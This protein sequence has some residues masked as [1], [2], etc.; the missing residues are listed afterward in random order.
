MK[1]HQQTG[2]TGTT[3]YNIHNLVY[4]RVNTR[5]KN[6]FLE[7]IQ[8][9][10]RYFKSP[11]LPQHDIVLNI[12]DFE[13]DRRHC[14]VINHKIYLREDYLFCE[15]KIKNIRYR[16]EIK[17]LDQEKLILNVWE[18]PKTVKQKLFP[19]LVAQN[20]FLRP[21]IDYVLLKKGA[22][23]VH[24][25][26][27]SKNDRAVVF[28]GRGGAHK[29]T[30]AMDMIRREGY[31][32]LGDDRV[33]MDGAGRVYAYPTFV[34]LF[35]FRLRK[36]AIEN[37]RKLDKLRYFYYRRKL[38]ND[39]SYIANQAKVKSVFSIVKHTGPRVAEKRIAR[40]DMITKLIMSQKLENMNSPGVLNIDAGRFYEYLVSYAY[41][42]PESTPASYWSKYQA[43]VSRAL[44]RH[45]YVEIGIPEIYGDHIFKKLVSLQDKV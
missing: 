11:Q 7:D 5:T 23:S 31:Q 10:F 32:F 24:A 4:I 29:T 21:L 27:F 35:T 9:P 17:G 45:E 30:I 33:L 13:P 20:V 37:Y 25:A 8:N 22:I 19:N 12:G 44:D 14:D 34:D 15:E 1:N 28:A 3:D 16:C 26:A 36:M 18:Q 40:E 2:A 6:Q 38:E 39:W 43:V 41:R 42:F